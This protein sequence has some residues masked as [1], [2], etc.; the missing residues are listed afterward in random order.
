M[1]NVR[2]EKQDKRVVLA[3]GLTVSHPV[4]FELFDSR[5]ATEYDTVFEQALVLGAYALQIEE[6]GQM[7]DRA[8]LDLDGRLMQIKMLFE[9]RGLKERSAA[10]GDILEEDISD[11]LQREADRRG[12]SD[13]IT[14]TGG[15]IGALPRRKVGDLV[16][17]LQD[18][19]R[20]V[21]VEA[22]FDKSFALGDPSGLDKPATSEKSAHGQNYLALASRESDIAIFVVDSNNCHS[23]ITKAGRLVFVPEQP[24][25]IAVVDRGRNDWGPLLAAYG[26]ARV[27]AVLTDSGEVSFEPVALLIKRLNRALRMV[28]SLD[29]SLSSISASALSITK[30]VE[31]IADTRKNVQAELA[32]LTAA[33]SAWSD[34]PVS[35]R[36][37][38]ALYLGE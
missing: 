32:T 3:E 25:F 21:V 10:K 29:A 24:G 6:I 27:L 35:A 26:V 28:D 23:S 19:P 20:K 18:V 11:V 1:A 5:P 17:E 31:D 7:L 33:V 4:V 9:L 15:L 34:N 38:M 30:N 2:L 8:S 12:W 14:R 22:K 13:S 36:Q 16:I 37:R